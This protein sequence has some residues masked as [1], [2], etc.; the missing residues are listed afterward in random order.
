MRCCVNDYKSR[1][2]LEAELEEVRRQQAAGQQARAPAGSRQAAEQQARAR[3]R[4][5][6]EA[7]LEAREREERERE[8]MFAGMG[9]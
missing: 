3:A 5:Q 6:L 7:Q 8:E 4:E 1:E 9:D 2:Q